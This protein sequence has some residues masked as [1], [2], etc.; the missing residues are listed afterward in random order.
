MQAKF[1]VLVFRKNRYSCDDFTQAGNI[2]TKRSNWLKDIQGMPL[3]LIYVMFHYLYVRLIIF[4]FGL[5]LFSILTF[6]NMF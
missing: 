6:L 1:V 2:A 5:A 3:S 4:N